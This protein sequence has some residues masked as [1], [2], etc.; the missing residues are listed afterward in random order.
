MPFEAVRFLDGERLPF[1]FPVPLRA[2]G[3]YELPDFSVREAA[4]FDVRQHSQRYSTMNEA[5]EVRVGGH[6]L[7]KDL[8]PT[9]L[10]IHHLYY[11]F[12]C[13]HLGT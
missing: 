11:W 1:G 13:V 4:A 7:A 3:N 2:L 9:Q 8:T 5:S 6:L 10:S 12:R